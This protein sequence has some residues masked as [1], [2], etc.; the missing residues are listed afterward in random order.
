MIS[1]RHE[2]R[3]V[4][5]HGH[6]VAYREAGAGPV[7]LLVHG[8][9]RNSATWRYVLPALAERYT[10]VAPD[11]PGHGRSAKPHGDYS[12]GTYASSLH[13]LLV[14]LG[15]ERATVVGQSLGRLLDAYVLLGAREAVLHAVR[16]RE[17]R[18]FGAPSPAQT[19]AGALAEGL[20]GA[21]AG[22]P[23]SDVV[24]ADDGTAVTVDLPG[25]TD[26]ASGRALG[27][28]EERATTVAYAHGWH[29]AGAVPRVADATGAR[30]VLRFVAAT[31]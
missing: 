21:A 18:G 11:L 20:A 8:M 12:L 6:T 7:V 15:H 17:P 9:A 10:V 24:V 22:E 5:I 31:P 19:L 3:E 4:T 13:D 29:A 23:G 28:L 2:F 27:R 1:D 25:A 16:R 26:A 30:V 14:A